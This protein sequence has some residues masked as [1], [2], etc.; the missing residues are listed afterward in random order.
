MGAKFPCVFNLK[1]FTMLQNS[2]AFSGFSVDDIANARAFYADLPGL[3]LRDNPMGYLE[4]HLK[5]NNG[6]FIYP[7]K[8]HEAAS[9]TILNF[10]V[11]NIEEAADQLI[12]KGIRFEQY[13]GDLRTDAKGIC[14]TARRKPFIAWVKH[15]AGNILSLIED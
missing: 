9:F 10:A 14:K 7:K 1:L 12:A 8:D 15:P 6:I 5:G 13:T 3:D 2:K 11:E 4:L